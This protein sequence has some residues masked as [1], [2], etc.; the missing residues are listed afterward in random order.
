MYVI[1]DSRFDR[2]R[3]AALR[4]RY[5]TDRSFLIVL[6]GNNLAEARR[7]ARKRL[8]KCGHAI[9]SQLHRCNLIMQVR[10]MQ[11]T[12][13]RRYLIL[14]VTRISV[15]PLL[16]KP[17]SRGFIPSCGNYPANE[18]CRNARTFFGLFELGPRPPPLSSAS[19]YRHS[20]RRRFPRERKGP[21]TR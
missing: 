2:R 3:S 1:G 5:D 15:D 16:A 7:V 8:V 19:P 14:R 11:R 10:L 6:D 12:L 9:P 13:L 18:P 21:H 17:L 4:T 20:F